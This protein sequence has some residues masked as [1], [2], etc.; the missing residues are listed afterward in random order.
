VVTL[1][2]DGKQVT[3]PEH[4]S[5]LDAA[6]SVNINIPT[7]CFLRDINEI[8][9]CRV[10]VVEVEG[11]DQLVAA[12]NNT[13]LDGMVVRTNSPKVRMARKSNVEFLLSQHDSECT[14]CVRSGNCTL[15]TVAND[16]GITSLP[17]TK[18]LP[19]QPWNQDFPLIRNN[20][21]CINCLRC[22]QVCE[23]VQAEGI[24]DLTNR[25]SHTCVGVRGG[26]LIE[27]SDC[28]LCGQCITHCPYRR[29]ARARRHRPRLRRPGGPRQDRGGA[30]GACRPHGLGR[31]VRPAA[32]EGHG[33]APGHRPQGHGLRL[34]V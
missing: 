11:I 28:A 26:G 30:G 18:H 23:K 27:D 5:I 13:V 14:S 21:K 19:H 17:Y 24:W 12:C 1:T 15:Q 34:R 8:G 4:T 6:K 16:L 3:V 7:L 33:P 29:P 20:D 22:I 32:R 10:C 25:S 2:I 31:A 9:A